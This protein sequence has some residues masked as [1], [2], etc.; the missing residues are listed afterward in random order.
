MYLIYGR[1]S[2]ASAFSLRNKAVSITSKASAN[3]ITLALKLDTIM[4]P[5]IKKNTIR[6]NAKHSLFCNVSTQRKLLQTNKQHITKKAKPQG[7]ARIVL[8]VLPIVSDCIV[9]ISPTNTKAK[10]MNNNTNI[11][12]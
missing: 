12:L 6:T 4:I 11:T 5:V 10:D 8:L 9:S 2:V 3:C 7:S 1:F